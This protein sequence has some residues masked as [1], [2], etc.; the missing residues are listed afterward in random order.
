[1]LQAKVP[2]LT[3]NLLPDLQASRESLTIMVKPAGSDI[4][5]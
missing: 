2:V 3:L 1:M 5:S 4:K